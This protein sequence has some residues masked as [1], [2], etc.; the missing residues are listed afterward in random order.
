MGN[1]S[2]RPPAAD[3]AN[4]RNPFRTCGLARSERGHTPNLTRE[5]GRLVQR[6][7]RVPRRGRATRLPVGGRGGDALRGYLAGRN[8]PT[9]VNESARRP[10][11]SPAGAY[12]APLIT[13]RLYL[14]DVIESLLRAATMGY[15]NSAGTPLYDP[16]E[17]LRLMVWNVQFHGSTS[18]EANRSPRESI[19]PATIRPASA[20]LCPLA[21][22]SQFFYDGGRDVHV[23]PALVATTIE[24]VAAVIDEHAPDVVLLQE[25]D[26]G[27]WRT[28]FVDQHRALLARLA[29]FSSQASTWYWRCPWVPYPAHSH[30]G[31][32][33][34]HLSV[35]SRFRISECIR[36]PLPLLQEPWRAAALPPHSR[37]LACAAACPINPSEPPPAWH[38][39][40]WAGTS[41]FSTCA[42]PCSRSDCPARA[43]GTS[44]CTT[45]TSPHSPKATAPSSG[46]HARAG[47]AVAPYTSAGHCCF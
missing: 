23:A 37:A 46:R 22:R 11:P 32:V 26:R 9:L 16:A 14:A 42:A 31:P 8:L 21:P 47:D 45:R 15:A 41:A 17:P 35:F 43:A 44:T 27:S 19:L 3:R 20:I 4:Q 2:I 18:L 12:G 29:Q 40:A 24:Q 7:R 5:L 39:I 6:I 30:V 36:T 10:R 1:N 33:N 38:Q 34:M 25:V 13:R 28:G